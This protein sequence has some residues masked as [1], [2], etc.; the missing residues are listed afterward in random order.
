MAQEFI[1]HRFCCTDSD[2]EP[3]ECRRDYVLLAVCNSKP[4]PPKA[5]SKWRYQ[6]LR[7]FIELSAEYSVFY[8]LH[9]ACSNVDTSTSYMIS[10]FDDCG[11]VA[12]FCY[13]IMQ[14]QSTSKFIC[15]PAYKKIQSKTSLTQ[16]PTVP[17]DCICILNLNK[18]LTTTCVLLIRKIPSSRNGRTL[19]SKNDGRS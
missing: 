5:Q 7:I 17:L 15:V 1:D 12:K 6:F 14:Q 9:G 19:R 11:D 16:G 10:R 4:C 13:R 18:Q 2:F 3:S 8:C